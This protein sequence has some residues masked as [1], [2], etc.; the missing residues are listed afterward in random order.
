MGNPAENK[1]EAGAPKSGRRRRV[2]TG[3]AGATSVLM[4]IGSRPV[5]GVDCMS[6]ITSSPQ[7]ITTQASHHHHECA[8][9]LRSGASQQDWIDAA[10]W[11]PPY[12]K[13]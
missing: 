4:T 1:I 7:A 10:A 12:Q 8:N 3:A 13:A 9:M 11:P 5:L 2:L 6:V